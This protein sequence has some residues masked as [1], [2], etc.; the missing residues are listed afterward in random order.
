MDMERIVLFVVPILNS[1]MTYSKFDG[2]PTTVTKLALLVLLV[3]ISCICL[4]FFSLTFALTKV[5]GMFGAYEITERNSSYNVF[6][7]RSGFFTLGI[8]KGSVP[9]PVP[10]VLLPLSTM[11]S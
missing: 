3:S 5:I 9:P 1:N 4:L 2:V 6:R 8:L 7:F 10:K 11:N